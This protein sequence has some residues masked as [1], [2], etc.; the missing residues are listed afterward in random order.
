M[1]KDLKEKL[2]MILAALG[3][4]DKA[5]SKTLTNEDWV[6]IEASFKEKY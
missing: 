5:K 2:S 1:F 6:A 4:T 3:F